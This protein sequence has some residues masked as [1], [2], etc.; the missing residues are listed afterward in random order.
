MKGVEYFL[1]GFLLILLNGCPVIDYFYL[2]QPIDSNKSYQIKD[3]KIY[4]NYQG[5]E[6]YVSGS[7]NELGDT[8]AITDGIFLALEINNEKKLL[9]SLSNIYLIDTKGK[10]YYP[11]LYKDENRYNNSI[12]I[13]NG[14]NSIVLD[15]YEGTERQIIHPPFKLFLGNLKREKIYIDLGWLK[16]DRKD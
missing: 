12:P 9:F 2:F 8:T 11:R 16:L 15:F 10:K 6:I 1:I 4:L 7:A 14:K 5:I 13:E 3:D